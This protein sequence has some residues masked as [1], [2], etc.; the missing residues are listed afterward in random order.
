MVDIKRAELRFLDDAF[1]MGSGYVLNFSDRTMSEWF[2]D[3]LR[4][5]IDDERYGRRGSSKANRLRTF[6]EDE[7]APLVARMMR[8]LW[9]YR[10]QSGYQPY[11]VTPE[12]INR[13]QGDA[14]C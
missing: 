3:E 8:L 5:N 12:E 1:G 9:A 10:E 2:E 13:Q 11:G 4:I 14:F 7:P 6:V